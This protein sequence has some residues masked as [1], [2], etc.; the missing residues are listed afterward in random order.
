MSF[1]Q[2]NNN[3]L[4]FC[5]SLNTILNFQLLKL[6]RQQ[7]NINLKTYIKK[8]TKITTIIIPYNPHTVLC[9]EFKDSLAI[10]PIMLPRKTSQRILIVLY[11][12]FFI[13]LIRSFSSF[14]VC[15]FCLKILFFLLKFSLSFFLFSILDFITLT[16]R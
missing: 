10:N 16:P 7:I 11:A 15:R 12:I 8:N 4:Y 5:K 9:K 6:I 13:F 1:V 14:I 3:L 2:F